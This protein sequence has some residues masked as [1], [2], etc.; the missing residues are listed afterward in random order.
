MRFN[1]ANSGWLASALFTT[2]VCLSVPALVLLTVPDRIF[3]QYREALFVIGFFGAWRYSWFLLNALRSAFFNLARY[4]ALRRACLKLPRPLP[5]RLYVV[6]LSYKERADTSEACFTAIT[7]TLREVDCEKVVVVSVATPEEAHFIRGVVERNGGHG[8]DLRFTKQA[9]GKRYAIGHALRFL[10]EHRKNLPP[11]NPHGDVVL[12]MD[13]DSVLGDGIFSKCLPH[14]NLD[15]G[16]GALTT[17]ET[18]RRSP[19]WI[20]TQWFRL[21]FAKRHF[22]MSSHALSYRVMTLTGRGSFVRASIALSS[23]FIRYLEQ[24]YIDHPLHGRI[25]FLL[26]DD[27]STLFCVLKQGWRMLYVPDVM[28]YAN[29]DREVP[30]GQLTTTLMVRWYGNM[31]RN[32][33]RCLS[34]GI[35]RRR[36][37]L[38]IWLG[39]LD[40]RLSMWTGLVGPLS[41]L[42]AGIFKSIYLI[43]IYFGWVFFVRAIQLWVFASS[44]VRMSPVMIP[45]MLYDQIVGSVMKIHGIFHQGEQ[46]WSKGDH[47]SSE[48]SGESVYQVL[49]SR[50]AMT[51]SCLLFVAFLLIVLKVVPSP[52]G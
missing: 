14:F 17:N 11:S 22:Y 6:V 30:F 47:S 25:R 45:L 12:L 41:A 29:E 36:L 3:A 43:P 51:A 18:V 21:K 50:L 40:Q 52:L 49:H 33:A 10:R 26:G 2:A 15:P 28:V 19:R 44:G 42:L 35:G 38:F 24:D 39:F 23:E 27:K 7:R 16:L 5:Q 31:L 37:P 48:I 1:F 8:I 4:P 13:G 20:I 34:L 32:N 9:H 46:H